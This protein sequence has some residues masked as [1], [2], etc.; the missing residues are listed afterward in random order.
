MESIDKNN[1]IVQLPL[2]DFLGI[3]LTE[4]FSG[5]F[6]S[7]NFVPGNFFSTGPF[8]RKFFLRLSFIYYTILF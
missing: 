3:F 2:A 4:R 5:D 8:C 6:F 7:Q 1:K